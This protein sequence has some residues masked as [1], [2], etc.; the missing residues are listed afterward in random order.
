M[1]DF[2]WLARLLSYKQPLLSVALVCLSS[3]CLC[4]VSAAWMLDIS[5]TSAFL[6]DRDR[7]GMCLR[8]VDDDVT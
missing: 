3:V 7:I 2:H 4:S 5:E 8:R 6:S 1:L